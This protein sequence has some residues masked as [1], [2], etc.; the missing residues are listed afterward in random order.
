MARAA[1]APLVKVPPFA[2]LINLVAGVSDLGFRYEL[3]E[4]PSMRKKLK[5]T[6]LQTGVHVI[7]V[8][9]RLDLSN[10]SNLSVTPLYSPLG[11]CHDILKSGDVIL[12][13]DDRAIANDGTINFRQDERVGL[14]HAISSLPLGLECQLRVLRQGKE[15]TVT[16]GALMHTALLFPNCPF[17]RL[18]LDAARF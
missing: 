1:R 18:L 2:T 15:Q 8:R 17:S 3:C 12:A 10:L 14:Q 7:R 6:K 5:M 9:Y 13:I 4:N 16:V 11:A